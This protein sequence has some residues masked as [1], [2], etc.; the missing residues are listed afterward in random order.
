MHP[1]D[2]KPEVKCEKQSEGYGY[3]NFAILHGRGIEHLFN[4]MRYN[5]A[6]LS[7][8]TDFQKILEAAEDYMAHNTNR[9]SVLLCR[10]DWRGHTKANW[11][12]RMLLSDQELERITDPYLLMELNSDRMEMRAKPKNKWQHVCEVV[13]PLPWV[14]RVMYENR[15]TPHEETDARRIEGAFYEPQG[16]NITVKLKNYMGVENGNWTFAPKP[17]PVTN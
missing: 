12:E 3:Y 6:F 14:L 17:P 13:G 15:A 10:Y 7:R 9:F 8:L 16:T 11:E 1:F 4:F 2:D 5:V